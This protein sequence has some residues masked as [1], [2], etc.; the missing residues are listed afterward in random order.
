MR[1]LFGTATHI[2]ISCSTRSVPHLRLFAKYFVNY[3]VPKTMTSNLHHSDSIGS[4]L[5]K[6]Q[7]ARKVCQLY[8][9]VC[10]CMLYEIVLMAVHVKNFKLRFHTTSGSHS[11]EKWIQSKSIYTHHIYTHIPNEIGRR[12]VKFCTHVKFVA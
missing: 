12:F 11:T 8:A 3:T 10:V 1:P 9:Y 5:R 2:E 4:A 6:L 7:N